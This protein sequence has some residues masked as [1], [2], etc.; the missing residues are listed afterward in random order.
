MYE[1]RY[2][3]PLDKLK[4]KRAFEHMSHVHQFRWILSPTGHQYTHI[5]FLQRCRIVNG[6]CSFFTCLVRSTKMITIRNSVRKILNEEWGKNA[7][8]KNK[9]NLTLENHC[10]ALSRNKNGTCRR[11]TFLWHKMPEMQQKANRITSLCIWILY[12]KMERNTHSTPMSVLHMLHYKPHGSDFWSTSIEMHAGKMS[13]GNVCR[14][15]QCTCSQWNHKKPKTNMKTK[16]ERK[17]RIRIHQIHTNRLWIKVH[18]AHED[19]KESVK[20]LTEAEGNKM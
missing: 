17:Q 8:Q 5:G 7:L 10:L 1:K 20:S 11:W 13:K 19:K 9:K 14:D 2:N 12:D 6:F 3:I 15:V 4:A 18:I 16:Q